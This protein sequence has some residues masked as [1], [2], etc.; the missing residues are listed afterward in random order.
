MSEPAGRWLTAG[1][2]ATRLGVKPQTLYAYVSRGLVRSERLAGP[3]RRSR[4][5]RADVERL[6][7]RQR[8]G[9]RAGSL[10]LVVDSELTLVEPEGRLYYRGRDVATLAREWSYERTA[11]WLWTGRDAGEPEPWV[12]PPAALSVARAVAGA[13]DPRASLVDHMRLACVAAATSD[14]LRYDRRPSAVAATGRGLVSVLVESLPSRVGSDPTGHRAAAAF[15]PPPVASPS[16]E[17]GRSVSARLWERIAGPASAVG[18]SVLDTALVLLADHDLAPSAFGARVAA[19]TWADPYLVVETGL[20]IL[21]GPLHGGA[22]VDVLTMLRDAERLGAAEAVGSRLRSGERIPGLGHA[23]YRGT[24]PRA[25]VLLDALGDAVGDTREWATV[26]E[27]MGVLRDRDLPRANIDLAIGALTYCYRLRSDAGEAMFAVSRC[28]GWL[29]HAI[30]E[31]PHR[32][33]F[34][35]RAVY[36]GARPN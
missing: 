4:Y 1:Q 20:G 2:A 7:G 12:A 26:D 10:E 28:A 35:P 3:G 23:V 36:T 27:V 34:R 29:A 5:D 22:S 21:G 15:G 24:D 25:T 13:V 14:P 30:E 6:A 31:Y 16:E 32:L 17:G 9:G 8:S 11:E 33:R 19:S 18:E